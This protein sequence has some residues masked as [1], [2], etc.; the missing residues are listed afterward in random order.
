MK[1]VKTVRILV[2]GFSLLALPAWAEEAKQAGPV[3]D[4][5]KMTCK[6]L[7]MGNDADREGG[8]AFFQGFLAGKK[9]NP[10]VDVNSAADLADRVKDFCLSNPES[11]VMQAF[12]KSAK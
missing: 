7:M 3:I 2:L 12:E 6:E 1:A 8:M 5:S 9:N 4:I 11:T 10:V